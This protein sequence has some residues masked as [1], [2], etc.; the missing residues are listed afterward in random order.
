MSELS[1]REPSLLPEQCYL[2][3]EWHDADY[4]ETFPVVNPATGAVIAYVPKMGGAETRRAIADSNAALP[5][6]R[7]LTAKTRAGILRSWFGLVLK[8]QEDLAAIVTAEHGKPLSEA[9]GEV[10]G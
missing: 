7:Q 1:L 10:E 2:S 4:G 3:G 5:A 8:H 9:K 6:W